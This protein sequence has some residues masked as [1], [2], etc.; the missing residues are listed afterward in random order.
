MPYLI[1]AETPGIV[2]NNEPLYKYVLRENLHDNGDTRSYEVFKRTYFPEGVKGSEGAYFEI[3]EKN[4]KQTQF[5][6]AFANFTA[7]V[8]A[9]NFVIDKNHSLI[10]VF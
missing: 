5:R 4:S 7:K 9:M 2:V 6:W 3:S 10:E 1:I 8:N